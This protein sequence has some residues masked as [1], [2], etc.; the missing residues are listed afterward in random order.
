MLQ[1]A[2]PYRF[3]KRLIL[4]DDHASF[5][6]KVEGIRRLPIQL[7]NV[8]LGRNRLRGNYGSSFRRFWKQHSVNNAVVCGLCG[9]HSVANGCHG[10]F[11]FS[12]RVVELLHPSDHASI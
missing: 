1:V 2:M 10:S 8:A 4:Q 11:V 6:R 9:R 12:C 3:G 5:K 7:A